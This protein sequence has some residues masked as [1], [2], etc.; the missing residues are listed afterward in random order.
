MLR[1]L[2]R[3]LQQLVLIS[4]QE[5]EKSTLDPLEASDISDAITTMTS[6]LRH[7]NDVMHTVAIIGFKVQHDV[8]VFSFIEYVF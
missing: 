6:V 1:S 5:L 4:V 3:S 7:V 2:D 8:V